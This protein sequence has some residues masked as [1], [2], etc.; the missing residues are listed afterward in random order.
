MLCIRDNRFNDKNISK[1]LFN[2]LK[3]KNLSN[4][5]LGSFR[6]LPKIHKKKFGVRPIINCIDNPTSKLCFFI[7]RVLQPIIRRIKFILKDLQNLIQICNETSS[8]SKVFLYSCDFESLYTNIKPDHAIS[9]FTSFIC[10]YLENN[11]HLQPI[12]FKSIL[13]LIFENNFFSFNN[14]FFK[15]IIG[16]PMGCKCGPSV[17]NLYIFLLEK[18]WINIHKPLVYARLIDDIFYASVVPLNKI[19]FAGH[20]G[21]LKLNI[22]EDEI[23]NFLDLYISYDCI[24]KRFIFSLYTKPT[25]TFSYLLPS[26]NHPS[27]IF[28]NIPKS[29]FVRIRRN[30]SSYIDYLAIARILSIQL[31][32]RN[33][34]TNMIFRVSNIVANMTRNKLIPYKINKQNIELD[35]N[36]LF[37]TPFDR[38][39]P[40][41]NNTIIS[42]FNNSISSNNTLN[43]KPV[44]SIQTNLCSFL[45]H[46]RKIDL[47]RRNSR[48]CTKPCNM[49]NCKTCKFVDRQ[50]Y[51]KLGKNFIFP[52]RNN[53]SCL[54]TSVVYTV[55]LFVKNVE[56]FI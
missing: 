13:E 5:R 36:I 48:F 25:N 40:K 50:Y 12:G 54:S 10:I 49:T 11:E 37:I 18:S 14:V 38:A 47:I 23:V 51:L 30:C 6:I 41:F 31:I 46:N 9:M 16:L 42:S 45:V 1:R 44:N 22:I 32:K 55:L 52:L 20:F 33:Y 28:N 21:Y 29:L 4:L 35:K 34:D 19:D 56:F 26:S 3:L 27:H 15:Q 7:D 8:N 2:I 24:T 53:C 39:I 17:A 43:I